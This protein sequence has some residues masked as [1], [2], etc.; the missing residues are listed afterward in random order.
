MTEQP[1]PRKTKKIEIEI[2]E[3]EEADFL[4]SLINSYKTDISKEQITKRVFFP[5]IDYKRFWE[6]LQAPIYQATRKS[7]RDIWR[8][9]KLA[10]KHKSSQTYKKLVGENIT[11]FYNTKIAA[12]LLVIFGL[13]NSM[14]ILRQ[15]IRPEDKQYFLASLSNLIF[16]HFT[17]DLKVA[18]SYMSSKEDKEKWAEEIFRSNKFGENGEYDW[19]ED[20][21]IIWNKIYTRNDIYNIINEMSLFVEKGQHSQE[22]QFIESLIIET[23]YKELKSNYQLSNHVINIIIGFLL[24]KL[25]F[26]INEQAYDELDRGV[27][28][29]EYLKSSIENKVKNKMLVDRDKIEYVG[30]PFL[31]KKPEPIDKEYFSNLRVLAKLHREHG[32]E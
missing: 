9:F 1:Q 28:W 5:F 23:L 2:Y 8:Y 30:N 14:K 3:D 31:D 13:W 15:N 21:T 7:I 12:I 25:G 22:N 26:L 11:S 17:R 32:I 10:S 18:L 6:S 19:L 16:N 24:A 20:N 29:K 27:V 4:L